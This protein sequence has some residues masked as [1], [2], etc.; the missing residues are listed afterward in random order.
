M[1]MINKT[2]LVIV[3]DSTL[4]MIP[5]FN[6]IS[7]YITNYFVSNFK[8]YKI[9]KDSDLRC[10]LTGDYSIDFNTHILESDTL[11][12]FGVTEGD[13]VSRLSKVLPDMELCHITPVNIHEFA[14]TFSLLIEGL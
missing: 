5:D 10:P 9:V 13:R 8:S 11:M 14:I 4:K 2:A 12:V 7:D 1:E 3:M 6:N